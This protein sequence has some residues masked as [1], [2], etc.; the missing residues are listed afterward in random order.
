MIYEVHKKICRK[1]GNVLSETVRESDVNE[2]EYLF[3]L[4]E[5]VH[6]ITKEE[7]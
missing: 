4:V 2:D 1:T 5:Y 6:S 3:N 7:K